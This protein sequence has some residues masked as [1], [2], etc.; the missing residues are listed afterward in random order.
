M[1]ELREAQWAPIGPGSTGYDPSRMTSVPEPSDAA[2][3]VVILLSLCAI[4]F[5]SR[6]NRKST[7]TP[8]AN[9]YGGNQ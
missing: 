5:A 4:L 3:F 6:K 7:L 2:L 9:R 1:K 8:T